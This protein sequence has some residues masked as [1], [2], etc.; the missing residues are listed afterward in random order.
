MGEGSTL[1]RM[2]AD[3]Q[4]NIVQAAP[5]RTRKGSSEHAEYYTAGEKILLTGGSPVMTDSL[6]GTTRGTKLTYTGADDTLLVEGA[7]AQPASSRLKRQ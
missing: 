1:E 3:G 4:V 7:P 5:D 6:K 2:I